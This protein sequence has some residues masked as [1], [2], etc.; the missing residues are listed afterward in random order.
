MK[1]II[2]VIQ[3]QRDLIQKPVKMNRKERRTALAKKKKRNTQHNSRKNNRSK[4]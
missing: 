1:E 3:K 4:K 2:D